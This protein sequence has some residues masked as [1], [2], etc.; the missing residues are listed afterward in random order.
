MN[1]GDKIKVF[2]KMNNRFYGLFNVI[3]LG[4]NGIVDLKI[5]NYYTLMAMVNDN[6]RNPEKGFLT[7][8]EL[9]HTKFIEKAEMSYHKDGSCLHKYKDNK[10]IK[11]SNPYGQG[12]RWTPTDEIT[13]FQPI[14]NIAIRRMEIYNRS[15]ET[16]FPKPKEQIFVCDND[17]FFQRDGSYLVICYVRNKNLPINCFTHSQVYSNII[18]SLNDK[19]DLCIFIQRH[20]YPKAV[21]Y[22]SNIFKCMVTPYSCNSVNFCNKES[23]KSEMNDKMKQ[24]IFDETFH[25]FLQEMS[26]DKFIHFTE[27]KLQLI[28]Q[29]DIFYNE[30]NYNVP[31]SKPLFIKLALDFLKDKLVEFNKLPKDIKQAII[32]L[33]LIELERKI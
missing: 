4:S 21:P 5:T 3:Q 28:D 14:F 8:D 31:I 33:W 22:Y 15:Y 17:D 13:D 12:E 23:S 7:E 10:I 26:D 18:T 25:R 30:K 9:K 19:L 16:L 6:V 20:S 1:K 29:F 27:D 11:Y 24:A 32:R 2:F